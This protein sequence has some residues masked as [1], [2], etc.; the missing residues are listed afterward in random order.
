MVSSPARVSSPINRSHGCRSAPPA[1]A[2]NDASDRVRSRR[3]RYRGSLAAASCVRSLSKQWWPANFDCLSK[4]RRRAPTKSARE[5]PPARPRNN[6]LIASE[7]LSVKTRESH[8]TAGTSGAGGA[9]PPGPPPWRRRRT[10]GASVSTQRSRSRRWE[11]TSCYQVLGRRRVRCLRPRTGK[12]AGPYCAPR[13]AA[14]AEREN[15]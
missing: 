11:R 6:R 3:R 12:T 5:H 7:L 8:R 9:F 10:P 14:S 1:C 4:V 15:A 2:K 13:L